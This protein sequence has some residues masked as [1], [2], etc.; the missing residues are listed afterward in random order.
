MKRGEEYSSGALNLARHMASTAVVQGEWMQNDD[1]REKR[2]FLQR[3][4]S[5]STE[6]FDTI[7]ASFEANRFLDETGRRLLATYAIR[8]IAQKNMVREEVP[9]SVLDRIDAA[10]FT[11]SNGETVIIETSS[12]DQDEIDEFFDGDDDDDQSDY[13]HIVSFDYRMNGRGSLLHATYSDEYQV[14]SETVLFEIDDLIA[15]HRKERELTE[16]AR[17]VNHDVILERPDVDP[18]KELFSMGRELHYD[19]TFFEMLDEQRTERNSRKSLYSQQ[20]GAMMAIMSFILMER[21]STGAVLEL[22]R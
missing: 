5:F 18:A 22:L 4:A 19:L 1:M 9:Q 20:R 8:L 3:Q 7:T 6:D 21:E 10:V 11:V 16:Y 12:Y 13:S 17:T 2:V 14:D 15:R